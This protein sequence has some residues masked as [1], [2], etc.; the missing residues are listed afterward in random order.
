MD[1]NDRHL[2]VDFSYSITESLNRFT[3]QG[4]N[5][6]NENDV[7]EIQVSDDNG[8]TWKTLTTY[9]HENNPQQQA[10]EGSEIDE[11]HSEAYFTQFGYVNI[12]ADLNEYRGKTVLVKYYFKTFDTPGFGMKIIIDRV[13]LKQAEFPE[14]PVVTVANITDNSAVVNWTSAQTDY[15][16]QYGKV[17]G[18]SYT[19][20]NVKDART[21]TLTTLD[22]NTEYEVKV[23]GLLADGENYSEWSDVVTF[24]TSDYP[25]VDAPENL[26]SDT[27]TL[28]TLCYVLLSWDKVAEAE[29]YEVA[30]RLSSSTEWTYQETDEAS[31]MLNNLTAGENYVWK[32]RA[33]CTHDRETAY[34]AQARF[35]APNVVGIDA[36]GEDDTD[37]A[38]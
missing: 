16:M 31:A 4:Y 12:S 25:A 33:F 34:S 27:E 35:V 29:K 13:S 9:T 1:I 15:Q 38:Y 23:R 10:P 5:K 21:Y 18:D 28:A 7:M 17:G 3:S 8:E 30:Y 20:V 26:K 36:I 37:A 11:Y 32:V 24:T 14:V 2:T 6:W 22:V 19:T